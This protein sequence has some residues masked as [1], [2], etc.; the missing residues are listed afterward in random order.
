MRDAN[1]T[2]IGAGVV[3]ANGTFVLSLDSAVIAGETINLIQ[4]DAA[5]NTSAGFDFTVPATPAPVSP[6]GLTLNADGSELSGI[7]TPGNRVEARGADGTLLGSAIAAADGS[8][9][10]TLQPPQANG[11]TIDAVAI[12]AANQSSIPT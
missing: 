7:A 1:G 9:T 8:F 2:V 11:E 3:A 12:D 10:L 5:G 4:T 6:T